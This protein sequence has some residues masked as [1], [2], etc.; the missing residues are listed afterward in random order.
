MHIVARLFNMMVQPESLLLGLLVLAL[1]VWR[2]RPRLARNCVIACASLSALV[3]W[4]GLADTLLRGL[5]GGD[6]PPRDTRGYVGVIVLGGAIV[7]DDGWGYGQLRVNDAAARLLEPL[8]LL[9]RHPAM[10]LVYSGGDAS[11]AGNDTPEAV[12]AET[13]FTAVG[14]RPDRALYQTTSRNTREDAFYTCHMLGDAAREPWLLLTSAA[15]M[16]RALTVFRAQGC[17][18][19]AYPVDFRSHAEARWREY[20]WRRGLDVWRIWLRE[21]IGGA[22]YRVMGAA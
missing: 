2:R 16:P 22:V 5:E 10:R 3:G 8:R 18:V 9:Q 4:T 6:A 15:H 1:I 13:F 12:F 14:I 17:N 19:T 20:H 7:G 21:T 11:L